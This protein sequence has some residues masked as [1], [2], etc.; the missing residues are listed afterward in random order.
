MVFLLLFPVIFNSMLLHGKEQ[1]AH[2]ST[3]L[4]LCPM[5]PLDGNKCKPKNMQYSACQ[6]NVCWKKVKCRDG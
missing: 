4:T 1:L 5:S 3:F 6:L 2:Y